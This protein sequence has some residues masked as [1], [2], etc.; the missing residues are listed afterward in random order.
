M[1]SVREL[2]LSQESGASIPLL[3]LAFSLKVTLQFTW[4]DAGLACKLDLS[5]R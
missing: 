1:H 2:Q 4:K 5:A 3:R